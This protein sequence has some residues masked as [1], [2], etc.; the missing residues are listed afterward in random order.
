MEYFATASGPKVRAAMDCGLLGQIV[1]PATGN[2]LEP[3]RRW[4]ADNAAFTGGYPGDDA[5][6]AWLTDRLPMVAEC[7]FAVAPDVPFG[8][9]ATLKLSAPMLPRI[10][11]LGYPVALCAQDGLEDLTVPWDD[12]DVL[13]IAGSTDWKLS[14]AAALIAREAKVRGKW[15]HMGRVNSWRRLQYAAAIGCD[16]CDGTY[17]A[18]GPDRNLP[19]LLD[20][21]DEAERQLPWGVLTEEVA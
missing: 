15:V 19:T 12:F 5:Y 9:A 4:C 17:L 16:S 20:W 3:G 18:F 21:L 1:T 6:L 2:R 11:A 7:A 10:R 13:F 8:A 14:P